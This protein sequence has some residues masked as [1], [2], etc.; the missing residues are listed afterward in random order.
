MAKKQVPALHVV[1]RPQAGAQI[2]Q[3]HADDMM[4]LGELVCRLNPYTD[5]PWD[6]TTK[7][8]TGK[9]EVGMF[10]PA[11][12]PVVP[13]GVQQ[14]PQIDAIRR[15]GIEAERNYGAKWTFKGQPQ[16]VKAAFRIPYRF[17]VQDEHGRTL[18][19]QTEYLLIGYAG[20]QGG[21]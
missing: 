21:G 20:E 2:P 4:A 10:P 14:A 11:D 6:A 16:N 13:Q 19:W 18:Y 1:P 3:P 8:R 7:T 5:L 17:P 12:L 9:M 15:I